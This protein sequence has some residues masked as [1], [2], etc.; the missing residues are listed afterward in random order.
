MLVIDRQGS[1]P[2]ID[3]ARLAAGRGRPVTVLSEDTFV[4][5]QLGAIGELA[6]WYRDAASLGIDLRPLTTVLEVAPDSV[7]VRHR[8]G[9]AVERL[10]ADCVV[11]AD[12]ELP[13]DTLYRRLGQTLPSLEVRRAGDCLAPRRV[14]HAVMEGA[15]AGREV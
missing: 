3:A 15:C 9:A 11:W 13:M 12:H 5:S 8:F 1:Y 14:L 4:S 7:L 6:P 2:A 10:E